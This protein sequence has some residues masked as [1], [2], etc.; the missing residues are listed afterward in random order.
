[1]FMGFIE[2]F[3]I[4][5]G[6]NILIQ[7]PVLVHVCWGFMFRRNPISNGIKMDGELFWNICDFWELESPQTEAHTDHDTPGRTPGPWC[8]VVGCA[9]LVH[10]LELYFGHK[11]A[12]IRKNNVKILAQSE[13]RISRNIRNGFWPVPGNAKQKRTEREVQS[14]RGSCPSAAMEAMK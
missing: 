14:R 9:H 8:V 7:C 3:Y 6:T 2:Q 10:W 13:L 4:I 12:Y 5:F 11:E 1:M